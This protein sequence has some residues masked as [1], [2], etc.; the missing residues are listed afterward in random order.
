MTRNELITHWLESA[1]DNFRS[2]QNMFKSGE[3]I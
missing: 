2:M 3:Y 1:E